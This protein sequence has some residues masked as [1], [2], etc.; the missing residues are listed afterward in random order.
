MKKKDIQLTS[1]ARTLGIMTIM[2]EEAETEVTV[3]ET[4]MQLKGEACTALGALD[5]LRRNRLAEVDCEP[6]V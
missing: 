1:L 3:E 5:R 4:V 2:V 6:V